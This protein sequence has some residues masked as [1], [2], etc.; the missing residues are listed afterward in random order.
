MKNKKNCVKSHFIKQLSAGMDAKVVSCL[1][2]LSTCNKRVAWPA[3]W[4]TSTKLT[5]PRA[6]LTTTRAL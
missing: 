3:D 4:T 5:A 1:L 2:P 6:K